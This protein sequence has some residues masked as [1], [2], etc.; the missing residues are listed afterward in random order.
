MAILRIERERSV[1]G[2]F[3]CIRGICGCFEGTPPPFSDLNQVP[4]L[5]LRVLQFGGFPDQMCCMAFP[6]FLLQQ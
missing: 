6:T 5:P 1:S 3:G 2:V 4:A